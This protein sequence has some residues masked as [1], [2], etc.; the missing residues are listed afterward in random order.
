[1]DAFREG[2]RSGVRLLTRQPVLGLTLVSI[3]ALGLGASATLFS[4]IYGLL[5]RP[6]PFPGA[7]DWM[8]VGRTAGAADGGQRHDLSTADFL[9]WGERQSS[10]EIWA[11]YS[12]S[13]A[14]VTAGDRTT[15]FP[16]AEVTP[17]LERLTG[18]PPRL[19]RWFEAAD[20]VPGAPAAV[21]VGHRLWRDVLGARDDVLGSALR[22]D[23]TARIV[24]GVMPEGF[25][26][27]H[28][29]QLWIPLGPTA[30][31]ADAAG[32]GLPLSVVATLAE[33]RT[34]GDALGELR[35][36]A[37]S[38][39]TAELGS[40]GAERVATDGGAAE[41]GGVYVESWVTAHADRR[42]R[43]AVP[44]MTL[45][46]LGVLLVVVVNASGLLL[47]RGAQRHREAAVRSALGAG[48][49]RVLAAGLGEGVALATPALAHG[50]GLAAR[51]TEARAA[52]RGAVPAMTLAVLGVLLVVVVN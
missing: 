51:S 49:G 33:G 32:G 43:G 34:V 52:H 9:A 15:P 27:P 24:I 8:A 4:L 18:V 11:G 7:G 3:L 38:T 6:L 46:V 40:E 35:A 12:M 1:M 16:A 21:V 5:L 42:L 48:R 41:D 25:L 29:Q 28:S 13:M 20:F 37:R 44:A 50:R 23:G 26:F 39:A 17:G 14:F 19:G 47:A 31:G 22:V 30:D 36:L 10:F 2:L 45:A